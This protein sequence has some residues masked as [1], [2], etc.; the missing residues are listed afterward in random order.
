[1][2]KCDEDDDDEEVNVFDSFEFDE[3]TEN[4]IHLLPYI[5]S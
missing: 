4:K 2:Y 5:F 3:L 1:M